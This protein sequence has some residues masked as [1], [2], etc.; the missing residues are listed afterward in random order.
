M[1]SCIAVPE[2]VGLF[3]DM[4][5]KQYDELTATD[6]TDA[7]ESEDD[8]LPTE[9]PALELEPF[10]DIWSKLE[11]GVSSRNVACMI[12]LYTSL[13]LYKG[14]VDNLDEEQRTSV[15][16]MTGG[17]Q[18]LMKMLEMVEDK[19]KGRMDDLVKK[20]KMLKTDLAYQVRRVRA[21]VLVPS[22]AVCSISKMER[23]VGL[24]FSRSGMILVCSGGPAL[25]CLRS[26]FLLHAGV[27]L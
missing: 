13:S 1:L 4:L 27:C 5:R 12:L 9:T 25:P 10:D 15:L 3:K 6:T 23:R 18:M 21:I 20:L 7:S 2:N 24:F 19:S 22:G 26:Y 8:T 16:K 14:K 17:D 11:P